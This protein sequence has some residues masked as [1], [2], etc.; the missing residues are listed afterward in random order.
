MDELERLP[1]TAWGLIAAAAILGFAAAWVW[2]VV[3]AIPHAG[4][5]AHGRNGS[6][7]RSS[8]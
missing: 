5:I 7:V 3:S 1:P 6:R 4:R 2:R 8:R